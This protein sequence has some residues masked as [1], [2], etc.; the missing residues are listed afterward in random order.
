M[1]RRVLCRPF[2]NCLEPFQTLSLA[3]RVNKSSF[4][5]IFLSPTRDSS[6]SFPS[7]TCR[8]MASGIAFD[9]CWRPFF[10]TSGVAVNYE[11]KINSSQELMERRRFCVYVCVNV[12]RS[13][14]SHIGFAK[15]SVEINKWHSWWFCSISAEQWQVQE[16]VSTWSI[17]TLDI[18]RTL[19]RFSAHMEMNSLLPCILPLCHFAWFDLLFLECYASISTVHC[20]PQNSVRLPSRPDCIHEICC[21]HTSLLAR[22]AL[23][24]ACAWTTF[25]LALLIGVK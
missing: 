17:N 25:L 21:R 20:A 8:W 9:I 13:F 12:E 23:L 6:C 24:L 11:G 16:S 1:N 15:F 7:L 3:Q 14:Q 5:F 19:V 4:R 2:R 18:P 22:S 10:E